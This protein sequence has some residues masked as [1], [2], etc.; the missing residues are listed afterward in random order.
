MMSDFVSFDGTRLAYRRLGEGPLLLCIPG[1]PG[2]ASDYLE[3]LGGL[4]RDHTL[5]LLDNRGT[6]QSAMPADPGTLRFDRLA[7]D[8]ESLRLHLGEERVDVLGHSAGAV[9]A[10]VWA[11]RHP[12]RVRSLALVTPSDRLQG[13]SR[14]DLEAL[15]TARKSEPWYEDA[16]EALQALAVT[17]ADRA[18]P[19][20]RRV[21]PFFYGRWDT[22]TRTHA[23]SA[24]TQ[25]HPPA[26]RGWSEG[27]DDVD[28]SSIL[29]GLSQVEAPVLVVGGEHD[30]V[31]GLRSV[32][33]VARSFPNARTQ[34]ISGA[35]HFPWVDQP[36]AFGHAVRAFLRR[37]A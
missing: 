8:L 2:R 16:M 24:E 7:D 6:G 29:Q 11:A 21:R 35:G 34:V 30:A 23:Q 19:L 32:E 10:Q 12:E 17:P 20:W 18:Q 31:T 3:D 26:E 5:V 1:G 14:E 9:V 33:R 36:E 13:G 22:R 25:I 27:A 15:R 28:V 4:H 37:F